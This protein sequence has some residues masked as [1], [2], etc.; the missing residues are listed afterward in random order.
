M[1]V[2]VRIGLCTAISPIVVDGKPRWI[3]D[4]IY[5][6]LSTLPHNAYT[7]PVYVTL[8]P[9]HVRSIAYVCIRK[10]YTGLRLRGRV[11][12]RRHRGRDVGGFRGANQTFSI[13]GP[14]CEGLWM[15][16]LGGDE[17]IGGG[18]QTAGECMRFPRRA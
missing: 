16:V 15:C 18:K 11:D 3:Q 1:F 12:H 17:G 7:M 10:T 4:S 14:R 5:L 8:D 13:A 2:Y 9:N 6:L